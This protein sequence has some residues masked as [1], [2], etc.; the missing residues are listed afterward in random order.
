MRRLLLAA[1]VA[2]L[3]LSAAAQERPKAILV[4]DGSGSMWG[5]IDGVTKIAIAQEVVGQLLG[6]LPAEQEL[7]LTV[8]GHRRKGDC[9]DIETLVAPGAASRE[10]IREAV[11]AIQPRGKTPLSDAVVQAAEALRYTEEA[12][13]VILVSDGRETCEVDP[14]EVGRRLEAA[15]VDFTAHVIGF[16]VSNP[17]DKAQLQCLAENTGGTFLSAANAQELS[18]ALA[19]VAEAEPM[20]YP[21][22]FRAT[23]GEGGPEI[24]DTLV[25][26]LFEDGGGPVFTA[27][28]GAT[29][30]WDLA[31]GRYRIE[32]LRPD[33]EALAEATFEVGAEGQ[34]VTVVFPSPL[35]FA[36][37][38]AP[39]SAPMGSLVS[40]GW[41]GPG[42]GNDY[43]SVA[44]PDARDNR[45]EAYT[46]T[47]KDNPLELR[48]PDTPG[49]YELRY[50]WTG[51]GATVI[52]RQPIEVTPVVVSLSAPDS[53]AMGAT[54]EVS[55]DGP[56]YRN[57]YIAVAPRDAEAR[58]LG[59]T[60]T[61]RGNPTELQMPP[62][63]GEYEIRY[64]LGIGGRTLAR[65]NITA[66][67]V[68]AS[69]SAAPTAQ[70]GATVPV[71]W[72]GPG[73]RNDYISIARPDDDRYEAYRYTR[74]GN[75]AEVKIPLEAGRYEFRYVMGQDGVV[76]ATLPVEVSDVSAR[77][78]H[79]PSARAGAQV[80][81]EWDGPG[82]RNDYV[83]I[84]PPGAER[85][86]HY[87]YAREG[88][89]M[90]LT[91]P[92]A[93]GEYEIRYVATGTGGDTV[94][95]RSRIVAEPVTASI[96]APEAVPAGGLIALQWDGP[97]Y[98]GDY[99]ALYKQGDERARVFKRTSEDSPM[100][101]E[102]PEGPGDYQL[103]YVMGQ[104]DTV[105][106][107]HD[108]RLTFEE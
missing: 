98:R 39:E 75:P 90:L 5:Q 21:T 104:D 9:T 29:L 86:V 83:A 105:L 79:V 37:L 46:Y 73:Y 6:S 32:A 76:L 61:R 19:T 11:N 20:A 74:Q 15:G 47:R 22:L 78:S 28:Q 103:R 93:P 36:A 41:E 68:T 49:R 10:A 14:C 18:T 40:V 95:A 87:T 23:S 34:T 16:D 106:A 4:L 99:I 63:A 54:I 65:K 27:R 59:Y 12:A 64:T 58:H 31:P 100:I 42:E 51:D 85:H 43:I 80:V 81:V 44:R 89:P 77:L 50:V 82:Y 96:T 60:Y 97:D 53:A 55:W 33:D 67:A 26:D 62:V 30:A 69:L 107:T 92:A 56:D 2:L 70:A 3:P 1:L 7:G 52:A 45:Y 91:L 17:E 13:T 8:Y 101:L 48:M 66:T 102:A 24:A 35:P 38:D 71:E 88:S 72:Q 57:D 94:L 108:I 25:W 84:L